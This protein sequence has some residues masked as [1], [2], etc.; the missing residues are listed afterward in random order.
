[1]KNKIIVDISDVKISSDPHDVIVTYSLGSC[2][3]VSVYDPVVRTGGMLH[4]QLPESKLD[5]E[6][7]NRN[8][9][10]FA[11]TGMASL[12]NS[13]IKMGA[14]KNRMKVKI[15]GGASM[16]NSPQG[17]DIGNRNHLALRKVLWKNSMFI[18]NEDVGGNAPRNMY[19]DIETGTV[20]VKC[21]GKCLTL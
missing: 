5:A 18:E 12:V 14:V 16:T 17:F 20:N 13:L 19:L 15:C 3:G 10:M 11:D 1:M 4:Y 21:Q 9:C 6:K 7:A 2:I 8:P